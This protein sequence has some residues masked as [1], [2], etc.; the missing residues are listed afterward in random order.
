M[1]WIDG[2]ALS[3]EIFELLQKEESPCFVFCRM[4]QAHRYE[5]L[6]KAVVFTVPDKQHA[7][8]VGI[9]LHIAQEIQKKA[10]KR[11][12]IV[13]NDKIFTTVPEQLQKHF[14]ISAS[15]IAMTEKKKLAKFI[16]AQK[17]AIAA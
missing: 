7:A 4:Q 5:K 11:V 16:S 3:K 14:R 2:D 6:I 1:L 15:W 13:S 10:L 17:S 12:A 9:L 8:D